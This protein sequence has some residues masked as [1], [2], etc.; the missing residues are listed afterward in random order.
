MPALT[1]FAINDSRRRIRSSR[2]TD[3]IA[4][5]LSIFTPAR[6]YHGN[7]TKMMKDRRRW[8]LAVDKRVKRLADTRVKS[9]VISTRTRL[10][11]RRD[12]SFALGRFE[13]IARIRKFCRIT[14]DNVRENGKSSQMRTDLSIYSY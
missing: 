1:I 3:P 11:K 14:A 6:K 8:R 9:S 12:N 13:E 7:D 10:P 2:S 5:A 4:T